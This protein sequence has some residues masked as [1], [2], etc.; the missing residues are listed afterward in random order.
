MLRKVKIENGWVRGLACTNQKVTAFRGIPYAAPPVGENRWR[1]PQK[2][3]DWE[4]VLDAYDFGPISVQDQPGVGDDIYCREWHVDPDIPMDEDCLYLNV[5]TP[6]NREDEKLPVLIWYHGGGFQWGCPNEMEF[7]GEEL[8][9]KGIVMVSVTYRLAALGFFAHP[10]ITAEAPEAPG[11]FGMLDQKF[12]LD[13]V[14]RNIAA[15]GGDPENITISGQSAGGGS[16][17]NQICCEENFGK[18]KGAV[19]FSGIIHPE[20]G[21]H[22]NDL[23]HP[24][25]LAQA[26][27]DGLD[28]FD[29][30][31]VSTLEQ[32]RKLDAFFIR[33][34]Y[35][36]FRNSHNAMFATFQ[37]NLFSKGD[38]FD[39]MVAGKCA[40]VPI[41][42]G[43]TAD[44]FVMGGVNI[45][46]KSVKSFMNG[47]IENGRDFPVY[48][49]RFT[50]DIPG[51]DH[52]GCFHSVD[53]WFWFDTLKHGWRPWRGRHFELAEQMSQYFVNFVKF[54]DP[55]Y[56]KA[57]GRLEK[58]PEL[59]E[60]KPY[61]A[62]EKFEMNF[63]S[64]G[65]RTSIEKLVPGVKK[66]GLNP[67][68]P[69]WEYIP[70]GEPYVFGDRVYVYG[71]HDVFNGHVFCQGDYVCWSAPV[72]NPAD[73]RFEGV[74]YPKTEDPRNSDGSM[75][76]YA[77]DV[78]IGPDGRYY[79]FYVLD[80]ISIVS[81]AVSD[82][83][84]GRY[85]FLGY[86]HYADGT[87]L[88]EREGDEPQ[89]DPGV[90]TEGDKTW[91]FTGFCGF[92]DK[93]RHGAMRTVLGPDMLTIVKEPEI[94]V[95]GSSYSAGTEFEGHAFFEAP[96]IRKRDGI[97]YFIYSSQVMHE[98]CYATS[99]SLDGKF[100]YGGVI[101][102][103]CDKGIDSY[104]PA[105]MAMA[106]GGN[107]HGSIEK[108][109]D[110]WYIFYHRQ[111]N[112][113]WYS[114][115]G[116]AE[117]IS[118]TEDGKIPQ[119]EI[120]S[121]GFNGGPLSDEG[122]YAT[123]LAC[124]LFN[125]EHHMYVGDP[126][127]PRVSQDGADVANENVSVAHDEGYVKEIK[128]GVT[129]GF[130]YF[131]CK[132]VTGIRIKV[133]GYGSGTFH[134]ATSWDGESLGSVSIEN[135]NIWTPYEADVKIPDGVT[136]LYI[137][138]EGHGNV[139]VKSFEF[140]HK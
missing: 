91:L 140:L 134:F 15:F 105:D 5:W 106:Y 76:L 53:L 61:T 112:N 72:N 46:E 7:T 75:C 135:C 32:A 60:W 64:E 39:L 78:T 58:H 47:A 137:R 9:K 65:A 114:R 35:A 127:A 90:L 20:G 126:A 115:Q 128:D 108:I 31:G 11:N 81:V 121:C 16:V 41:L 70:D 83:P 2:V 42:A 111:T 1:A 94:I 30:L 93:S 68:L 26:E 129:M 18:I 25:N 38:S 113:T 96:S 29:A 130:K 6:A 74:I 3:Q 4:G 55:N 77:P 82:T 49:Y 84:A 118:F 13:W 28:F 22:G 10:E 37:D 62:D 123:Y 14:I 109:G 57:P 132:G 36:E 21:G 19:I 103:N 133:R 95:P 79:L 23:F 80:H 86:V 40:P 101:V 99:D 59:P 66:Q 52:P 63:T 12:A 24:K 120:T 87:L 136:A 51:Y 89:F 119:V 43:N 110:D 27:Q 138:Y 88:G 139:A 125:K 104:K 67:Y 69:S 122:E 124:H 44:E 33:D 71:S 50:P 131:D 34:R 107:N 116:C 117:K 92:G 98:L 85:K 102:S 17:M 100:S 45:V 54:H 56:H 97:Y 48:Y 8:A 73:W